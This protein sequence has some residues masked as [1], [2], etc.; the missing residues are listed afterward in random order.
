MAARKLC[1]MDQEL[2]G[3][4]KV[5]RRRL[6]M[7]QEELAS[8]I[9]ATRGQYANW[10]AGTARPPNEYIIKLSALGFHSRNEPLV[11]AESLGHYGLRASKRQLKILID[12]LA[13]TSIAE[14]LRVNAKLELE[15]ALGLSEQDF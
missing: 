11:V 12:I 15:A 10:E 14:P 4:L 2:A 3:D 1:Y 9:G 13:D 7:T 8:R 6:R 5:F